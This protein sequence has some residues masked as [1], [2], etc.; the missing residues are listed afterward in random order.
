[1]HFLCRIL[2]PLHTLPQPMLCKKVVFL[3]YN[4]K[5]ERKG[6]DLKYLYDFEMFPSPAANMRI[7][8]ISI[9][10]EKL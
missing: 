1:M 9:L 3:K 8:I 7:Q 6:P 10:K 4:S 2:V 5:D